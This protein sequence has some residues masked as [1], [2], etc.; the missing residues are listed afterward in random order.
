MNLDSQAMNFS[1]YPK[2]MSSRPIMIKNVPL[3]KSKMTCTRVTI[4]QEN[5]MI[6]RRN[7]MAIELVDYLAII[8]AGVAMRQ[9]ATR[10]RWKNAP[11][12]GRRRKYV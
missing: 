2:A 8:Y 5:I 6:W 1:V 9:S 12:R 3:K 10:R 11:C 7:N 4:K